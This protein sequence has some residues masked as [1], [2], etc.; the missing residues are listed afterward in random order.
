METQYIYFI[1]ILISCQIF[2]CYLSKYLE[3]PRHPLK[4]FEQLTL[5]LF[6]KTGKFSKKEDDIILKHIESKNGE[7]DLKYLKNKLM[8]RRIDIYNRIERNL[9]KPNPKANQKFTLDEDIM[10]VKHVFGKGIPEDT[11]D[12]IKICAEK[13]CWID[14][15]T[16]MQRPSFTI[17]HR[18][19]R[20]IWPRISAHVQEST[21]LD[22]KRDFFQFIIDNRLVSIADIDENALAERFPSVPK[23]LLC[24][25]ATEFQFSQA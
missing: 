24:K 19:H 4:V 17:S 6:Y 14:L 9:V 18:W 7:Y 12:I 1:H 16:K 22:W 8:R 20:V 25:T 15:E 11:I 13:R 3:I 5:S 2:G 23:R 10:I 21:N